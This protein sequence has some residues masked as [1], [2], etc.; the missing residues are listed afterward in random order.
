MM[1][2]YKNY[3]TSLLM[4][5]ICLTDLVNENEQ[6]YNLKKMHFKITQLP[7]KYQFMWE[8]TLQ[9]ITKTQ[10]QGIV[11]TSTDECII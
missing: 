5:C 7:L 6:K 9:L 4:A 11:G 3:L 1:M 10:Q 8:K 2:N